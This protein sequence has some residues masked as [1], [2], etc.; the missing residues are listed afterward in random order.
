MMCDDAVDERLMKVF[1]A[2]QH[3]VQGRAGQG[4]G[5]QVAF[6]VILTRHHFLSDGL[7]LHNKTLCAIISTII[8]IIT[9]PSLSPAIVIRNN[10]TFRQYSIDL[11]SGTTIDWDVSLQVVSCPTK[12]YCTA[13]CYLVGSLVR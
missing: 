8:N 11:N 1:L 2:V 6:I 10:V 9:S 5:H 12:K 7:L 4:G 13:M 3:G